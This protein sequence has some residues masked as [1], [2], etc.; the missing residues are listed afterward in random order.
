MLEFAFLKAMPDAPR[1]GVLAALIVFRLLYLLIPLAFSL[2][3]VV[4]FERGRVA[5]LMRAQA[6]D[7]SG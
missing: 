2:V 6:G 7:P 4:L 1:S 3:A 5:R